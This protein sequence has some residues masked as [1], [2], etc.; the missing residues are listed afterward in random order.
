MLFNSFEFFIFFFFVL[1][2]VYSNSRKRWL[3]MLIASYVFYAAWSPL[4]LLLLLAQTLFCWW[5]ANRIEAVETTNGKRMFLGLNVCLNLALLAFFKYFYFLH[6]TFLQVLNLALTNP[7]PI[8]HPWTIILPLGISFHTF[9]GIAYAVDVYRGQIR[10]EKKLRYFALFHCFFPQLIAGPIER[11]SSLL[12]QMSSVSPWDPERF[13]SGAKWFIW[14]LFK[15]SC[16]ADQISPIVSAVYG[17]PGDYLNGPYLL[18][19]TV[20]FGIQIYCDFSGYSDMALGAARMLGIELTVNFRQPYFSTSLAEFWRRWHITLSFWFRDYVYHPLGG[21]R[22]TVLVWGRNIMIVFLLSGLWHGAAWTFVVWGAIHGVWLLLEKTVYAVL[23]MESD[24]L[25]GRCSS[26]MRWL[27]TLSVVMISWIF[28]R[29]G[30]LSEAWFV[31]SHCFTEFQPLEY[32]AFKS[33]GVGGYELIVLAINMAV[34]FVVDAVLVEKIT[35]RSPWAW[36]WA[37]VVLLVFLAYNIIF[38]GIFHHSEF[39]YFQF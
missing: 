35:L 7:T 19:A 27:V 9:Q 36:S 39:I 11:A 30:S 3:V 16:I 2:L 38:H 4:F 34:L 10:P 21:N 15:K 1:L 17:S 20:L 32:Q 28:F 33:M 25:L 6:D 8:E 31:L 23:P 24:S 26:V 12:P 18:I 29:A 22:V 37:R 14:G 13:R 5:T